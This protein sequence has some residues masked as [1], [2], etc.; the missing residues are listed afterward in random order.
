ML[1]NDD[2]NFDDIDL[3]ELFNDFDEKQSSIIPRQAKYDLRY[4]DY[5]I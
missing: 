5:L 1:N 4:V 3:D 2:D